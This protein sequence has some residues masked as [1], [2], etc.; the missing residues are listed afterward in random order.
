M[1]PS[2]QERPAPPQAA[3]CCGAQRPPGRGRWASAPRPRAPSPPRNSG[4]QYLRR[5]AARI[6]TGPP[7]RAGHRCAAKYWP[8][9]DPT[10]RWCTEILYW[11]SGTRRGGS[12]GTSTGLSTGLVLDQYNWPRRQR[13]APGAP[14]PPPPPPE[15]GAAIVPALPSL[16]APSPPPVARPRAGAGGSAWGRAPPAAASGPRTPG[17][18]VVFVMAAGR[19]PGA[20]PPASPPCKRQARA[21]AAAP[22]PIPRPGTPEPGAGPPPREPSCP[23]GAGTD[24]A[25]PSAKELAAARAARQRLY[26]AGGGQVRCFGSRVVPGACVP[27]A[28]VRFKRDLWPWPGGGK[29]LAMVVRPRTWC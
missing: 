23:E 10:G 25:R 16:A 8:P 17:G 22:G 14:P 28:V 26:G 18:A 4:P 5:T 19:G 3:Q 2:T 20:S 9:P 6:S 7:V 27:A 24:D 12:R 15:P 1:E 29:S 13:R 21:A 11:P